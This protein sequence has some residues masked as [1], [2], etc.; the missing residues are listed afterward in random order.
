MVEK[1]FSADFRYRHKN[2]YHH[3]L[4]DFEGLV[5]RD[6][7]AEEYRG[8]W[9]K[10]IFKREAPLYVEIGSG[11]GHF[12]LDF[13]T[14]NPS[15]NFVGIDYRFKRSFNLAKKLSK[16]PVMN[17]RLLRARGERIDFQFGESEVDDLFYFFPD[18]W[19]KKRHHKKRPFQALFLEKAWRV[20]RPGGTI[21]IKTDQ[22]ELMEWMLGVLEECA[23]FTQKL[24]S[25]DM[26]RE[27]GEH[28]LC[29]FTTKFEKIFLEKKMAIK[30]LVI[31]S[32]KKR[33]RP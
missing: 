28:F 17:A 14:K 9:N 8:Q 10:K 24:L 15:I 31:E 18:P 22:Q 12:M 32:T 5:L 11:Y 19:P 16:Y 30:A 3:R 1:T 33:Q 21:S 29:H 2:P 23:L 26:R 6:H 13:C 4:A 20:L 27:C 7:E 25:F